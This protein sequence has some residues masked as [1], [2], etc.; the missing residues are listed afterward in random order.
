MNHN[1]KVVFL[2]ANLSCKSFANI[3]ISIIPI[4]I[5]F[6]ICEENISSFFT[7]IKPSTLTAKCICKLSIIVDNNELSIVQELDGELYRLGETCGCPNYDV[8]KN[9]PNAIL[10]EF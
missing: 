2:L 10:M 7:T 9:C 8:S 5:K 3:F 6:A 4:N 1:Y